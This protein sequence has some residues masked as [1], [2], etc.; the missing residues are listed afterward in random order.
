VQVLRSDGWKTLK[1]HR[2]KEM[3]KK[4]LAALKKSHLY[5]RKR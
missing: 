2:S 1:T 5:G 3:A 4:H